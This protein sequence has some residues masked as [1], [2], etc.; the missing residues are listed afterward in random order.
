M[1]SSKF[2]DYIAP[3]RVYPQIWRILVGLGLT[4]ALY[5][6]LIAGAAAWIGWVMGA[7]SGSAWFR[8]LATGQTPLGVVILLYSFMALAIGPF[9]A[10]RWLHKRPVSSLFGARAG[11]WRA[12]QITGVVVF[13]VWTLF[14]IV[15]YPFERPEINVPPAT[16]ARWLPLALPALLIQT[17]AEEVLFR[18]YL[19]QQLAARFRS[20][21]IWMVIPSFL[22]GLLHF[23]GQHGLANAWLV[24]AVTTL[25]GLIAADLTARTGTL[26]ASWGLHFANNAF[27]ILVLA[28][29]GPLDGLALFSLPFS[30]GPEM[31]FYLSLDMIALLILWGMFRRLLR[32]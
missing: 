12:F 28:T 8:A 7:D 22:F 24:V 13:V 32:V 15:L 31:L 23:D 6:G 16:W 25:F 4:A 5:A 20:P 2:E 11:G 10:V 30:E 21:L 9:L 26:G 17:G 1:A 29:Q 19:Q 18:G 3:A 27:A 14:F